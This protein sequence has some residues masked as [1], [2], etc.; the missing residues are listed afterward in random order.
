MMP[1]LALGLYRKANGFTLLELMVVMIVI[2]ISLSLVIP[3]LMKNDDDVLNE[4]SLRLTSLLEY[5]ADTA[6]SRGVWLGWSP[7]VSGYRFLQHDE[8]KDIWQPIVNDDLLRERQLAEGVQLN[9][10]TQQQATITTDT[11]VPFSPSGIYAP[12]QITLSIGEKKRIVQGNLLGKFESV[13]PNS[14]QLPAL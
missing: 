1:I 7:T 3:N 8:D 6:S 11:L 2:G 13:N 9:A 12:V 4:E 10:S 5:A 14:I